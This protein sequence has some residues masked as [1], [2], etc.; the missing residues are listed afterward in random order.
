[1]AIGFALIMVDYGLEDYGKSYPT[2][3]LVFYVLFI[4]YFPAA[5][6]VSND[7]I[8][9]TTIYVFVGFLVLGF[10]SLIFFDDFLPWIEPFFESKEEKELKIKKIKEKEDFEKNLRELNKKVEKKNFLQ[11]EAPKLKEELKYLKNKLKH[12]EEQEIYINYDPQQKAALKDEMYLISVRIGEI[13]RLL[14]RN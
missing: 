1:M 8:Y 12:L 4:V 11:I 10:L 7:W 14:R 6:Y 2:L 13:S 5:Y 3:F 9:A